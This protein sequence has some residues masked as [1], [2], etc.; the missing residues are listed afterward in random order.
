V[1]KPFIDFY[2]SIGFVP[3]SQ[4]ESLRL[5]HVANR[6]NL[7]RK[8]GL[9]SKVFVDAKVLEIGPGS[10][11]NSLDLLRRGI[12][13]LKLVDGVPAA[14]NNIQNR[15][16]ENL[17]KIVTF[18]V[19][20][21]SITLDSDKY[22]LVICEGVIPLQIDP[23]GFLRNAAEAVKQGGMILI[24]TSDE[25]SS[26][27]EILRRFIIMEL[28]KGDYSDVDSIV[29]FLKED[30]DSLPGMTRS[31]RDWVLDTVNNPWIGNLFSVA[32]ACLALQSYFRPVG[33][34]PNI[35]PDLT[36][37]K[38]HVSNFAETESWSLRYTSSAHQLLDSRINE[39]PF[40]APEENL[41]LIKVC[42]EI[43][44]LVKESLSSGAS[45]QRKKLAELIKLLVVDC[46]ALPE[47]TSASLKAF[48][49]WLSSNDKKDLGPFH[50]FW[51]RGQQHMLFER[52]SSYME[53]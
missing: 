29:E 44:S 39:Y 10:G 8:L 1:K 45:T 14:L 22:D 40:R 6:D 19:R 28:F 13:S 26:L 38:I 32:D 27:S 41:R 18:E 49:L 5:A 24:T 12:H 17:A 46:G 3:T 51:G 25:I 11:E 2:T 34:T 52:T 36:W 37:Y 43:G 30:F 33:I 50:S 35:C 42:Q 48:L 4:D 31:W 47:P 15:L 7:Y 53:N 16:G 23:A 21:A 9:H 20:D